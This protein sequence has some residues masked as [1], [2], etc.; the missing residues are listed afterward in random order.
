MRTASELDCINTTWS[1]SINR[2][3]QERKL[4]RYTKNMGIIES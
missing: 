3:I 4:R 1:E 2:N